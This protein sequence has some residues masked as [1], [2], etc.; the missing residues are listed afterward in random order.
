MAQNDNLIACHS[1]LCPI[2]PGALILPRSGRAPPYRQKAATRMGYP[3]EYAVIQNDSRTKG[4]ATRQSPEE[5]VGSQALPNTT[6]A[7]LR[8]GRFALEAE[9][10]RERSGLRSS[11][12]EF[13]ADD[14]GEAEK[15]GCEQRKR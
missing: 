9:K 1:D 15:A 2:L 7:S 12:A 5:Q 4:W 13:A 14:P 8:A 10:A 6:T 3:Q 11:A